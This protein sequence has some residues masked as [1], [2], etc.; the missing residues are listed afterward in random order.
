MEIQEYKKN[1]FYNKAQI[2][3]FNE[4]GFL[5]DTC[6]TL[7]N[8]SK[9]QHEPIF[10][11]FP[12]L[13][14]IKMSLLSLKPEDGDLYFPRVEVSFQDKDWVFDFVFR[15]SKEDI[16][17]IVWMIQ[18]L[19]DQYMYLLTVQQE[20]NESIIKRQLLE[21][22]HHSIVLQ[23]EIEH[24]NKIHQ[25]R[26]DYLN[27]VSHDIKI[28]VREISGISYLL[29]DFVKED[30]GQEYLKNLSGAAQNLV[31]MIEQM[32]EV[33]QI[34]SGKIQFREKEFILHELINI[35]VNTFKYSSKK[36]DVPVNI[37]IAPNTPVYLIG[38]KVRLSQ[39][40]YNLINNALKNTLKGE[41]KVKIKLKDLKS[42]KGSCIL[43]FSIID[44]GIGI[45]EQDLNHIFSPYNQ[46]KGRE[47]L[48]NDGVG[49]GLTIVKEL[50]EL[51]GG[52]VGVKSTVGE[53]SEFRFTLGFKLQK[54]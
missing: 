46:V 18:D 13:E 36:T 3:L 27:K 30:K 29:K 45:P 6:D 8:V 37:S 49:L 54:D 11:A 24:L 17:T 25:L 23:K 5:I 16:S 39:I 32:M 15:R 53:G 41:V 7:I 19:T 2:V 12:F 42:D 34:D 22:R 21:A 14:G 26:I 51:Q 44:T 10:E 52:T 20:R 35:V 28:P 40:L 1:Y 47:E 9:G 43:D 33:S 31:G 50:V 4:K 48:L 38:D